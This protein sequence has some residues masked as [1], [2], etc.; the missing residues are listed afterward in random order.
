MSESKLVICKVLLPTARPR[1]ILKECLHP[2]GKPRDIRQNT[3]IKGGYFMKIKGFIFGM[4]I[5]SF[6]TVFLNILIAEDK[7]GIDNA[8]AGLNSSDFEKRDEALKYL[9]QLPDSQK[10]DRVK[11]ALINL[12][13]KENN[14]EKTHSS[15]Q[16]AKL[17]EGY[18]EYLGDLSYAVENLKDK[19]AI[20]EM[21][22]FL[23][24]CI[25]DTEMLYPDITVPIMI[26]S[27]EN[28]YSSKKYL[29]YEEDQASG[30]YDTNITQEFECT[31]GSFKKLLVFDKTKNILTP[32][33]KIQIRKGLL[34]G[35][36]DKS[37]FVR[38]YAMPGLSEI[39]DPE[40]ISILKSITDNDPEFVPTTKGKE[41][42][43]GKKYFVR[44]EARKILD[45]LKAEGKI[46]L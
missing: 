46:K 31:F 11:I 28:L 3:F 35:V 16:L 21:I 23:K 20:P 17:G 25:G 10:N 34:K 4:A 15:E 39:P 27:L 37:P 40:V 29:K 24:G 18:S 2:R 43:N 8:I 45:K 19:R 5:L 14:Y 36:N 9:D 33:W 13:K 44:E 30:N 41:Y 6:F 32:E 26:T 1:G 42:P 38:M 7:K 22:S 12:I